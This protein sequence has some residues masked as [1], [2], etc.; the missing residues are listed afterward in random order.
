[1]KDDRRY[2]VMVYDLGRQMGKVEYLDTAEGFLGGSG[3][4]ARLFET[5]GRPGDPYDHPGQPLIF[6][7]GPLTGYFPLMSKVV[8]GFVSPYNSQ[9]AESHAGGRLA[10]ALRFSGYHG[11]V[12]TGQAH[13]PSCFVLGHDSLGLLDVHYL[14]GMDVFKAGKI[15][16]KIH[17]RG[18]GNRSIIRIGP[19]GENGCSFASINVD[20]YRHFGRLGCGSAM[21]VKNLKGIIIQGDGSLDLPPGKDYRRLYESIYKQMTETEAMCKYH[22]LGTPVNVMALNE[23]NALPWRNMQKT[24]DDGAEQVSGE[25]FA[26]D[27]LLRK[28]ACSGCPVGCIH[29]GL[30]REQFAE[31]HEF[32]YRQVS[33]DH[34]PI[35]SAGTMLD[36]TNAKDVLTL[37]ERMDN[38]GLDVMSAGVSLAWAT[39]ALDKGIIS[40]KET[41]VPLEFGSVEGYCHA[42]DHLCRQTNEF[43]QTLAR[44]T[45]AAANAYGGK[46]FACVL[47]QE[48]AGYATGE[49]FYVSQAYGFR[50]SHLDTAGYSYDQKA[51]DKSIDTTISFLLKEEAARVMLTCMVSCLFARGVYNQERIEEALTVI[52]RRDMAEALP[53]SVTEVQKARWRLKYATGYDPTQIDIP[54]RLKETVNWKGPLDENFMLELA[55]RYIVAIEGMVP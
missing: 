23:L 37:L 28:T 41:L 35:F 2:R 38:V 18:S 43:Y 55:R 24:S 15:L 9:Y 40:E 33:Y 4:A 48:M 32:V 13:I 53:Q 49:V 30:L 54:T 27:L 10:L 5:Y 47:G 36:I 50:H 12:L 17:G 52:G 45:K 6:A 3:L 46:D 22:D 31:Q 11:L 42:I 25:R 1:M 44:G 26:A 14:W 29:V 21:G 7:I 20:S 8:M 34:E 39:E 51:G 19:A 16:R